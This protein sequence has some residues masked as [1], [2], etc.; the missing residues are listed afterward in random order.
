MSTS[1][2]PYAGALYEDYYG[3]L[4]LGGIGPTDPDYATAQNI[5]R[6][7]GILQLSILSHYI[8][9]DQGQTM[10]YNYGGGG[11]PF[12]LLL[13][14]TNIGYARGHGPPQGLVFYTGP[15]GPTGVSGATGATGGTGVSGGTGPTEDR[16]FPQIIFALTT[17]HGYVYTNINPST[18]A[19]STSNAVGQAQIRSYKK[20]IDFQAGGFNP[21]GILTEDGGTGM[22]Y[23]DFFDVE[24]GK[25]KILL[26]SDPG[27]HTGGV[28]IPL[29][30]TGLW[31]QGVMP[32]GYAVDPL[33]SNI[34][35]NF[36]LRP[37]EWWPYMTSAGL[38]VYDKWTGEKLNHPGTGPTGHTGATGPPM[39]PFE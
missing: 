8:L 27:V 14:N 26:S 6:Q 36:E 29:Y 20:P 4:H 18:G 30:V 38:P 33:N 5:I 3:P 34:V 13:P 23:A 1:I 37:V 39:D 16:Y 17:A 2:T 32:N 9:D 12:P 24:V 21:G 7:G 10:P 35:A 22:T 31:G 28:E 25:L 15:S 19:L 11:F